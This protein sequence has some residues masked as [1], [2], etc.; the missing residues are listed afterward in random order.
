MLSA[1]ALKSRTITITVTY[2]QK[3][4]VESPTRDS[5]FQS[6]CGTRSDSTAYMGHKR[7]VSALCCELHTALNGQLSTWADTSQVHSSRSFPCKPTMGPV[8]VSGQ[9]TPKWKP[10]QVSAPPESLKG[11]RRAFVRTFNWKTWNDMSRVLPVGSA[12]AY[13]IHCRLQCLM[14]GAWPWPLSMA[15]YFMSLPGSYLYLFTKLMA[16]GRF[17]VRC[18]RS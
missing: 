15:S 7:L 10:G 14:E 12:Y 6:S 18:Y 16:G 11:W 13:T 1:K 3:A 17:P 2:V 9:C 5:L 8:E 4:D